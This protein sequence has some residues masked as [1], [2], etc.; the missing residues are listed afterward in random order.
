LRL[1]EEREARERC[2]VDAAQAKSQLQ[3]VDSERQQLAAQLEAAMA[4]IVTLRQPQ[5]QRQ[6]AAQPAPSEGI[7][8]RHAQ[9]QPPQQP[10]QQ[11]QQQQ[12][13]QPQQQPQSQLPLQQQPWPS[14]G[15]RF[16]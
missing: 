15:L 11:Q 9:Q 12:Q 8:P 10:P 5:P 16:V 13:Q 1:R 14:P 3:A 6:A 7:P 2:Q 4:T